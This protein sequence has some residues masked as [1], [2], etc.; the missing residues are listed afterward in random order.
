[1]NAAY[2]YK[3]LNSYVAAHE[4]YVAERLA[5]DAVGGDFMICLREIAGLSVRKMAKAL[6]VT[7]SYLSKVESGKET[8]SPELAKKI[9]EWSDSR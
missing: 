7:P 8:L 6:E 1:M 5:V 2:A 3:V 4:K 9:L